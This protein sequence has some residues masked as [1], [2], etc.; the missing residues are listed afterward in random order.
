MQAT[1]NYGDYKANRPLKP[2]PDVGDPNAMDVDAITPGGYTLSC[3][4]TNPI[5]TGPAPGTNL[6]EAAFF[7]FETPDCRAQCDYRSECLN[8][9]NGAAATAEED[10]AC[11]EFCVNASEEGQECLLEGYGNNLTLEPD[12]TEEYREVCEEFYCL[13]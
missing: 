3:K 11:L 2:T 8:A 12:E 5:G 9:L 13:E 10:A 6:R 4:V 7:L 1:R